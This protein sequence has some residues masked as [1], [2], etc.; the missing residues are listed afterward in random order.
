M[1][2]DAESIK[3][4][5]PDARLYVEE[6]PLFYEKVLKKDHLHWISYETQTLT[7]FDKGDAQ[8]VSMEIDALEMR[9]VKDW[10]REKYPNSY[11]YFSPKKAKL[12]ICYG[13]AEWMGKDDSCHGLS[14]SDNGLFVW[15]QVDELAMLTSISDNL[16][17]Y[18]SVSVKID[19]GCNDKYFESS[20]DFYRSIEVSKIVLSFGLSDTN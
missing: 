4:I 11:S 13:R 12:V 8:T 16:Q 1:T 20:K 9:D 15:W 7:E 6:V 10:W 2:L 17:K 14:V 5:Y 18:G 19:L 3:L